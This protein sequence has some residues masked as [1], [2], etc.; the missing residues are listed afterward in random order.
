[1]FLPLL[2]PLYHLFAY[3]RSGLRPSLVQG[4]RPRNAPLQNHPSPTVCLHHN[5]S[6]GEHGGGSTPAASP[7]ARMVPTITGW[8]NTVA[9]KLP[10]TKGSCR[11]RSSR[12]LVALRGQKEVAVAVLRGPSRPFADKKKLVLQLQFFVVL[13][14][15]S[16]KKE[17]AVAVLRGPP[18]PPWIK[19]LQLQFFAAL[20]GQ[21][22]VAVAVLRGP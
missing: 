10:W 15:P 9:K 19:V 16:W 7:R 5:V 12:P 20:R 14:G 4:L 17:V 11:C 2:T 21:K 18:C 22:E 13:S 3:G 6:A 1:M 8:S